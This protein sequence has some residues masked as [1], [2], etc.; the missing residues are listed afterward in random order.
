MAICLYMT[1]PRRRG[2]ARSDRVRAGAAAL[3]AA[4]DAR[5]QEMG[6]PQPHSHCGQGPRAKAATGR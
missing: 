6:R 1:A 5:G 3:V 2:P 4:K